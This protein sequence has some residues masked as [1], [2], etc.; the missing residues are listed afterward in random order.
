MADPR[1]RIQ[2]SIP[3]IKAALIPKSAPSIPREAPTAPGDTSPRAAPTMIPVAELIPPILHLSQPQNRPR[4]CSRET[5]CAASASG[6]SLETGTPSAAANAKRVSADPN[7]TASTRCTVRALNPDALAKCSGDQDFASRTV[8]TVSASIFICVSILGVPD[9]PDWPTK[10]GVSTQAVPR[11]R[12]ATHA[13][14]G[15]HR[16]ATINSP[17]TAVHMNHPCFIGPKPSSR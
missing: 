16:H 10:L 8:R 14:G 12:P 13:T 4:R 5:T 7:P 15:R 17:T 1:L 3:P 6:I 9:M 11:Q 2:K